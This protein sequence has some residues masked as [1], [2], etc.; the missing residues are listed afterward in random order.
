M[1]E[2]PGNLEPWQWPDER[3]HQPVHRVRAARAYRPSAWKD[4]ARCAVALSFDSDH[5]TNELREGGP[6][7]GRLSWG[8]Y[9]S[10]VGVPRILA[11]L[12]R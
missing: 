6:S 11:L 8:Q 1:T 3:W 12:R 7:I 5:D 9:G 4:G 2:R 10:R